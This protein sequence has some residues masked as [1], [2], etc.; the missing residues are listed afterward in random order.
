MKTKVR[1]LCLAVLARALMLASPPL[2]VRAIS[3]EAVAP[4]AAKDFACFSFG[5]P[6]SVTRAG[7]TKVTVADAFTAEKGFGF[8][9]VEGLLAFDR[10]G[11]EIVRPRDEYTAR[12]YGA[13]R[14]TSDL[15]CAFIEGTADN[16]FIVAVPDGE[17]T[18]WLVASDAEWDPPLFEVW[19]NGQKKLDVRIPRARFV[20]VEPFQARASE[21]RLRIEFKGPHGWL[22]NGLVIGKAGAELDGDDRET[23]TGHLLSDRAGAR[24][25][26]GDQ[27]RANHARRW[28]GPPPSS[29]KGYVV[30]PADYTEPIAPTFVPARAAIG[31]PLTAFA[32]PGEFEPATFGLSARRDL[33]EV[34]VEL[35][36]FVADG[37]ADDPAA[38]RK[39]GVV[40]CWPQRAVDRG[41]KGDY[42]VVPEMIEAAVGRAC[43]RDGRPDQ[44]VVADRPRARRC[45]RRT[46]PD[47]ADV[48]AGEG[49]PHRCRVAPAGAAVS[50]DADPQTSTGA[51]GWRASRRSED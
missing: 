7:F 51:P 31:K 4:A 5:T 25:L 19:A 6:T 44:A 26:E 16:A 18:V 12:A 2:I 30:F 33:G 27:A 22:L 10:G 39:V 13:Y 46:L 8:Q 24:Q 20:F 47:E 35:S 11:S 37:T 36:D 3:G 23:R 38:E 45:A 43:S 1:C 32:T 40:R 48:A 14:T 42:Q 49:A 21:G 28:S 34:A 41:G 17:Y 15:T 29:E 50:T 9:S